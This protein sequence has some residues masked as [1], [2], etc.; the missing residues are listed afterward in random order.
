MHGDQYKVSAKCE[1]DLASE[2]EP[3]KSTFCNVSLG[4]NIVKI[5][6]EF[7]KKPIPK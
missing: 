3:S 5:V 4:K 6:V 2:A 1:N 7:T